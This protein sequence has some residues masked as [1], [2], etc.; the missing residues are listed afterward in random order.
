MSVFADQC[1][2]QNPKFEGEEIA[3]EFT[4]DEF[5]ESID[6]AWP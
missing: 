2:S 3:D 5:S 6:L 1:I 4:H